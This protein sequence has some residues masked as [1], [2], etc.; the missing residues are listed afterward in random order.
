MKL[1]DETIMKVRGLLSGENETAPGAGGQ[2]DLAEKRSGDGSRKVRKLPHDATGWPSVSDRSMILRS[3]MAYELGGGSLP[4][5]GV[6][7]VTASKDLVPGDS[8]YLT[9]PDLPEITG[10]APFAR[11][12]LV[13]VGE[14]TLGEGKKL[15]RAI[16]NLEY[17]RYHF[18]PEGFMLRVSSSKRRE[19]VRIGKEAL[20]KGLSFA[21]TGSQM[22]ASFHTHPEVEAVEIWYVTAKDFPYKKLDELSR[23]GEKVTGT[24]DHMMQNLIM[25]CGVCGLKQVC[26][27]VEGLREIHF[28]VNKEK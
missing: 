18:Y 6:T 5:L 27:E 16:R 28:G 14:D 10:D 12:A 15:Y 22:V 17:T 2:G 24:L 4:A 19:S 25:D 7:L 11:I 23:E 9:G 13:R 21:R 20:K 26:D 1:Y 8:V 3:D